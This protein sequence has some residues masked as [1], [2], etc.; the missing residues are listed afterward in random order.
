MDRSVSKSAPAPVE[1]GGVSRLLS[2]RIS[3]LARQLARQAGSFYLDKLGLTQPQWRVLSAIG[4]AGELTVTEVA[5][6]TFMDRGQT[7]RTVDTLVKAGLIRMRPDVRDGRRILFS[8][9]T[10]GEE[11][12]AAGLPLSQERQSRLTEALEPDEVEVFSRVLDRLIAATAE[13]RG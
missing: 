3:V 4:G 10:D 2:Y 5:E 7:S 13:Q 12:Y 6:R 11:K 9:S 8:L 1:V